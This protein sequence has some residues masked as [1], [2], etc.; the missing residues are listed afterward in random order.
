MVKCI[1]A[2]R[3]EFLNSSF[4]QILYSAWMNSAV[5][6]SFVYF[7]GLSVCVCVCLHFDPS[8]KNSFQMNT[9][10]HLIP[11]TTSFYPFGRMQ[12][13][14]FE[15][16]PFDLH[17]L[18]KI[19]SW[20]NNVTMFTWNKKNMAIFLRNFFF[21]FIFNDRIKSFLSLGFKFILHSK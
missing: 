14:N 16:L 2:N 19:K 5:I 12:V 17:P 1:L 15:C 20:K 10:Q 3:S 18:R 8:Y 6:H 7:V 11:N 4:R 9:Q 21:M 13:V